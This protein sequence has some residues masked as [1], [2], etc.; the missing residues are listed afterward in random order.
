MTKWLPIGLLGIAILTA[1]PPAVGPAPALAQS[2]Y[3]TQQARSVVQ[4]GQV[5]PLSSLLGQVQAVAPGEIV[6]SQ[7]CQVG[8]RYVYLLSVLVGGQ[9]QEVRVDAATGAIY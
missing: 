2:C 1:A 9:V 5:L 3:S 7:L 6:S 4:D 8:G